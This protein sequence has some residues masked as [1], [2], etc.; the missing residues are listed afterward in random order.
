MEA[1][2]DFGRRGRFEEQRERLDEVS[3]SLFNGRALTGNIELRAQGYEAVVL[4]LDDRGHA[5]GWLY[6][7]SLQQL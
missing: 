7:P 2:V 5:L 3:S 6:R 4:T 1:P